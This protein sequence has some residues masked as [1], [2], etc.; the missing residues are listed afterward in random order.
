MFQPKFQTENNDSIT[1]IRTYNRKH[2][3]NL[4]KSNSCLHK[5][6]NKELKTCFQKKKILSSTIQPSN[7]RKLL[8]TAKSERLPVPKQIKQVGFFPCTKL[9]L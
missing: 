2:N 3:I 1:F 6:E 7:L 4:K 9:H 8:I 5:I